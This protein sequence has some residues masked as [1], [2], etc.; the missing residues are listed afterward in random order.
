MIFTR[1]GAAISPLSARS[2]CGLQRE[3]ATRADPVERAD[4]IVLVEHDIAAN[5]LRIEHGGR[6]RARLR[7]AAAVRD[8]RDRALRTDRAEQDR[9]RRTEE[10]RK[11]GDV[12][13]RSEVA[14]GG[15]ADI[16]RL[17]SS[18]PKAVRSR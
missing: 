6:N 16:V 14:G 12:V 7:D 17:A 1:L 15:R 3:A 9:V 10:D 2:P 11:G 5:G 8:E 13:G 18:M 4:R